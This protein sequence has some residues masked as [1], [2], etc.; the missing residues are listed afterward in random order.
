MHLLHLFMYLLLLASSSVASTARSSG[1][2]ETRAKG[3]QSFGEPGLNATFDYVIVGGGTAGLTIA[4][5]LAANPS[6]SVAVIEAGG[7]YEADAGNTSVVPG[8][9]TL[10]AGTDPADTNPLIDW[11]FVTT[12]QAVSHPRARD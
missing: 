7:F 4:S 10:Y 6:I 1:Y 9:C 11:G 2:T 8:Y 5:R 3:T 12:P